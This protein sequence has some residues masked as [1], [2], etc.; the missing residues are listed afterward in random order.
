MSAS[1]SASANTHRHLLQVPTQLRNGCNRRLHIGRQ[2]AEAPCILRRTSRHLRLQAAVSL[3]KLSDWRPTDA[4]N[5]EVLGFPFAAALRQILAR[6][7]NR[8]LDAAGHVCWLPPS[9]LRAACVWCWLRIYA[10]VWRAAAREGRANARRFNSFRLDTPVQ[11]FNIKTKIKA[12]MNP[13]TPTRRPHNKHLALGGGGG[14]AHDSPLG[15][16]SNAVRGPTEARGAHHGKAKS[17]LSRR[18]GFDTHP[19]SLALEARVTKDWDGPDAKIKKTKAT[20]AGIVSAQW[21]RFQRSVVL[22]DPDLD[23]LP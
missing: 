14:V 23:T 15:D 3:H 4:L 2:D 19:R 7:Q 12:T 20:N 11:H 21:M 1:A 17:A 10:R 18:E 9:R 8:S 13:Q 22:S 16:L 6:T 5:V